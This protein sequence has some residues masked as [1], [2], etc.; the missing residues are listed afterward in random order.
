MSKIQNLMG[1]PNAIRNTCG[2]NWLWTGLTW[3]NWHI[4]PILLACNIKSRL[5]ISAPLSPSSPDVVSFD[6]AIAVFMIPA[7]P[8]LSCQGERRKREEWRIFIVKGIFAVLKI[9]FLKSYIFYLFTSIDN[10]FVQ[11]KLFI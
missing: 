4:Y 3:H 2:P 1:K 9:S 10:F 5:E 11:L 7:S 8:N 6:Y